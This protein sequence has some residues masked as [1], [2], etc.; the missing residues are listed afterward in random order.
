MLKRGAD[1]EIRKPD[2]DIGAIPDSPGPHERFN[3]FGLLQYYPY[4]ADGHSN[5]ARRVELLFAW[6]GSKGNS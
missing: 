5:A 4:S 6:K 3:L 2:S 1:S